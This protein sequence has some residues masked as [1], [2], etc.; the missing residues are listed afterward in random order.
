M[1]DKISTLLPAKID[2]NDPAYSSVLELDRVLDYA[3][4]EGIRNI[5]LTGPFGSGKSSVLKTL[6]I[7][8][9]TKHEYLPISLATLKANDEANS[10]TSQDNN[11]DSCSGDVETALN[12][13]IEYSILQ[14]LVYREKTATVANSRFKRISYMPP[15]TIHRYSIWGVLTL[16]AILI[17]FEP[18][19]ARIESFYSFFNLGRVGN[20]IVDGL[21]VVC[22]CSFCSV[23][24]DTFSSLMLIPN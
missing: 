21:C 9:S 13:R 18:K 16:L 22:C 7:D 23:Y 14:Q 1:N 6:M 3:A 2:K 15:K 4:K 19:F 11:G 17:V 12:R 24:L 5:A 20:L 8:F 10:S